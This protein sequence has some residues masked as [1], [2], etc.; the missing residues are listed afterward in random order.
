MNLIITIAAYLLAF[1]LLSTAIGILWVA[2]QFATNGDW[3]E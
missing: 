3:D 1:F 2:Y